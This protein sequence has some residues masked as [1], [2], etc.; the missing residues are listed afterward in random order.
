MYEAGPDGTNAFTCVTT[1]DWGLNGNIIRPYSTPNGPYF[2]Y[3]VTD[4]TEADAKAWLKE[5]V[6]GQISESADTIAADIYNRSVT[7]V[8][9]DYVAKS[10][11]Y[12][13]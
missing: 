3:S 4:N 7:R 10:K 13:V 1:H 12:W 5:Y 6:I 9:G 8:T 11:I 2:V